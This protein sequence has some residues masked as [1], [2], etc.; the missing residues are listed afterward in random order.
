M[1]YKPVTIDNFGGL[2][3]SSDPFDVGLNAAIDM[4][5][6]QITPRGSI[7]VREGISQFKAQT[8]Y[9]HI[10]RLP[11]NWA[12]AFRR[13]TSTISMEIVQD[14]VGGT[15]TVSTPTYTIT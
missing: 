14:T 4:D 10:A 6:V 9:H 5:D 7:A 13:A 15:P 3:L 11:P 8:G 2:N 12:V 1:P